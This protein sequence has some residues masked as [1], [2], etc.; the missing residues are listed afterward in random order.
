VV[1]YILEIWQTGK[2]AAK[3][4]RDRGFRENPGKKNEKIFCFDPGDLD[5]LSVLFDLIE[6]IVNSYNAKW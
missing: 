6:E 1:L 2:S 4:I 3:Y 5:Y